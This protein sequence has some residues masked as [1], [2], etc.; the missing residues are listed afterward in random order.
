MSLAGQWGDNNK[1]II[2]CLILLLREEREEKAERKKKTQEFRKLD[3]RGKGIR[4]DVANCQGERMRKTPD[5]T[6]NGFEF[7]GSSK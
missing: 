7:V 5:H 6:K 4:G 3:W 2:I 1:I